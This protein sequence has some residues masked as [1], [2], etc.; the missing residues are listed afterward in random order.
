M[1]AEYERAQ[2]AE[3]C[4]RGKRHRAQQGMVNVL[5]GAPYGYRYVRKSESSTAYYEVIEAEANV[6][7]MV[8]EAY[9]QQRL[10]INAMARLLNERRIPTRTATT[11]WERSTVWGMLRNPAY[12]GKACYGKTE[13]RPRQ[14]I[15]RPLR[16]RNGAASRDSANHERPRQEWIE[17]PVP[18][19]VSEEMFALAQEQLQ[20]KH[21]SFAPT[22]DGADLAARDVSVSAVWLC[23]VSNLHTNL[24]TETQLLSLHRFGWIS[25][26][27][28]AGVH[29]SAPATG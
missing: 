17:V 27:Q 4:R 19:L 23:V 11:R 13:L 1:I 9:T 16:Q 14:R 8:F 7:R 6:V 18:P 2:I 24:Q 25:P 3:R 5:S 10:S 29:E 26:A 12:C 21:A 15:T 20:K 22:Y 28:R